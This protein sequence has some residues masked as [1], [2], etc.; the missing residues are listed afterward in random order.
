MHFF[1]FDNLKDRDVYKRQMDE[2]HKNIEKA[3]HTNGP[4]LVDCLID[5]DEMVLPMLPPGGSFDDII[6]EMEEN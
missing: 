6:T 5:K 2:L 1:P 3:M 4:V